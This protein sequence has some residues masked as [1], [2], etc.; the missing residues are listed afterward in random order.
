[1]TEITVKELDGYSP[2]S[3]VFADL[4]DEK[5]Y[6]SG[7][8]P[9]AVSIPMDSISERISLLPKD[10]TVC[11]FCAVGDWSLQAAELLQD[12]GYNAVHLK[13]GY[14]AYKNAFN[15]E[16]P[17]YLD[18]AANTPADPR[19]LDAYCRAVNENFANPNSHHTAGQNARE[20]LDAATGSIAELLG[21]RPSEIIYTSGASES[22]NLAVKGFAFSGRHMGKHIISTCLEHSS[23]SAALTFLQEA[24]YEIDLVNILPDGTVDLEHLK[25]LLC[26]DTILVSVCAVDSELGVIQPVDGIAQLVKQ[27]PGCRFHVDATQAIGKIPFSFEGPDSISLAPHKF[28]GLGSCGILFKKENAVLE[29]LIHGGA[30]TTIYRSGT[31]DTAMAAASETALRIAVSELKKRYDIVAGHNAYLREQLSGFPLVRINSPENAV[32]HILNLS[33]KGVKSL[34]MQQALDLHGIS[35]STKSA[36]SVPNT[37][38]RAVYAVTH[39]RKN[40]LCSWRISLSHLTTRSELERFSDVFRECYDSLTCK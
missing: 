15:R 21:V 24:G 17:V 36:C 3:I 38:S 1:M 23:V 6:R 25:K 2:D 18:Y 34:K 4:R 12:L 22:N 10:K 33:V 8:I 20:S 40:A 14:S 28:Y 30:S 5:E 35:V 29:P 9:G 16:C 31:P 7:T 13:G 32:P 37:P 26:N 27:Y 19:V 11:V 39:D